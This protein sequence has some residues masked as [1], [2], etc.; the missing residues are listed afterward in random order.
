MNPTERDQVLRRVAAALTQV[1]HPGSGD[2]VVSSG[3]VR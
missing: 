3:R 2:D 1:V